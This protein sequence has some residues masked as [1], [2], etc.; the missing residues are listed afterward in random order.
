MSFD[1]SRS[2]ITGLFNDGCQT[3]LGVDFARSRNSTL[4]G[5]LFKVLETESGDA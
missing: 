5:L 4:D 3:L 2:G 1:V